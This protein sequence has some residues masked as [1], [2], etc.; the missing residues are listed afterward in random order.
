M[1]FNWKSLWV[2]I[3]SFWG[4]WT[5][6]DEFLTETSLT[7]RD[8]QNWVTVVRYIG[9]SPKSGRAV[10]YTS[11]ALNQAEAKTWICICHVLGE[12]AD[13][14]NI[15]SSEGTCSLCS[16]SSAHKILTSHFCPEDENFLWILSF[17]RKG[18]DSC[19]VA[20]LLSLE[21]LLLKSSHVKSPQRR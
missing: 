13:H 2:D 10:I 11:L 5:R 6:L 15:D 7:G 9:L 21:V 17:A 18:S 8:M 12:C 16:P 19:C 14:Q 1:D 3:S 4:K 20:F